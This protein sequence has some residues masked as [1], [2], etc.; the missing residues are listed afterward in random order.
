MIDSV[1]GLPLPIA[2]MSALRDTVRRAVLSPEA[3]RSVFPEE[4]V[5]HARL[6]DER[7]LVNEN[8]SWLS[9]TDFAYLGHADEGDPPGDIDP[10]ASVLIADLGPDRPLA[11]D[12]RKS[13]DCPCVLYLADRPNG[14]RWITVAPDVDTFLRKL[15]L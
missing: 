4:L 2:L 10:A 12:Y 14:A 1:N 8:M 6:Y 13:A 5:R 7:L 9:E 15:G 3:W 11:L